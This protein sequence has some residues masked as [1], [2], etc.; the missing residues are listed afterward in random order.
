[1]IGAWNYPFQLSI[2]PAISAIAAGNTVILK[3]SEIVENSAQA[4][5]DLVSSAF[6][7]S[8]FAVV[9]GGPEETGVCSN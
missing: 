9:Q 2:V 8:L 1:M 5:Q 6:D 4:M 7:E 3:P